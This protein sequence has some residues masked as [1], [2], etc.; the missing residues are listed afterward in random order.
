MGQECK[1]VPYQC[2]RHAFA[3]QSSHHA[4]TYKEPVEESVV[5]ANGFPFISTVQNYHGESIIF[6]NGFPFI[7]TVQNSHG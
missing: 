3:N 1:Y 4:F 6:A 7:S 2:S 5:F